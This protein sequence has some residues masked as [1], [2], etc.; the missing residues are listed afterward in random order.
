MTCDIW[1][2]LRGRAAFGTGN[3]PRTNAIPESAALSQPQPSQPMFDN[4]L[5]DRL[6]RSNPTVN[7]VV[8]YGLGVVLIASQWAAIIAHPVA[9]VATGVLAWLGW[10]L[11]EYGIHRVV[12][13]YEPASDAGRAFQR[14][15]HGHHHDHPDEEDRTMMPLVVSLPILAAL[16]GVF[17][18]A[19]GAPFGTITTGFIAIFF[20]NYDMIHHLSHRRLAWFPMSWKR[21]HMLHHHRDH[22]ANFGVSTGLW[23]R[24]FGT[25]RP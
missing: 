18:L 8:F 5:V 22:D 10:T 16:Y 15:A 14:V 12:F 4:P 24:A 6:T 19:F 17:T 2:G 1:R 23:D 11:A 3:V 9:F 21:R 20:M 13:H 7:A 25:R